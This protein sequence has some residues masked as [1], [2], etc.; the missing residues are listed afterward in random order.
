L[1]PTNR[2]TRRRV[3]KISP[4]GILLYLFFFVVVFLSF[5]LSVLFLVH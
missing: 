5:D 2:A 1:S 3:P 4:K